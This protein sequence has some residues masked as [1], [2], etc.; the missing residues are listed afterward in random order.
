[1][2]TTDTDWPFSDD[3]NLAVFTSKKIVHEGDWIYYVTH[4]EDDGAWQFHPHSGPTPENEAA[5][6]SLESLVK[7]DGSLR[8]LSDLPRGWHA[9]RQSPDAAWE[10]S[11]KV[12]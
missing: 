3:R 4:D 1:M 6:V 7:L 2:N 8:Q 5:V 12:A 9:W 11:Q 10:R